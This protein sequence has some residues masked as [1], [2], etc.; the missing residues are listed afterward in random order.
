MNQAFLL[1]KTCSAIKFRY[2]PSGGVAKTQNSIPVQ[3]RTR[4]F[5]GFPPCARTQF[6][7]LLQTSRAKVAFRV[8]F[9]GLGVSFMPAALKL[10]RRS[11]LSCLRKDMR[12]ELS[13][14]MSHRLGDVYQAL[15]CTRV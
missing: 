2:F 10:K 13:I 6:H 12:A 4:I 3:G 1:A 8:Y 9:V 14:I 15:I 7:F 11:G 5:F